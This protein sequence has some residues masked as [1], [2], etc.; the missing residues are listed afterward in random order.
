M[1][2]S[3]EM[4]RQ[5]DALFKVV[6]RKHGLDGDLPPYDCTRF[7]RPGPGQMWLF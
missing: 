3:G 7:R 6:A 1:T 5:V 2:G 4:A